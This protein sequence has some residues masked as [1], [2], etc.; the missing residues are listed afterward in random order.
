M[1]TQQLPDGRWRAYESSGTGAERLRA[2]AVRNTQK[3]ARAAAQAM[4]ERKR[5][6]RAATKDEALSALAR[7]FFDLAELEDTT[8][9]SRTSSCSS[10]FAT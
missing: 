1:T 9:S 5:R 10:T 8:S 7:D 4:I 3:A 2:N 6:G